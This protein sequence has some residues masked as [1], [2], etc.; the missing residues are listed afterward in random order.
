M[1][2]GDPDPLLIAQANYLNLLPRYELKE[3]ADTGVTVKDLSSFVVKS[4]K[5]IEKV[6]NLGNTNRATGNSPDMKDDHSPITILTSR[7]KDFFYK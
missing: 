1:V 4:V 3:N 5:E 6:M 7:G 2:T